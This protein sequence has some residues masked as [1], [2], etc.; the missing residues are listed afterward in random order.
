MI[1]HVQHYILLLLCAFLQNDDQLKSKLKT[2]ML[3]RR[4]GIYIGNSRAS[5]V[6]GATVWLAHDDIQW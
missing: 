3:T 2:Q 6:T 1:V 4:Y 5:Y